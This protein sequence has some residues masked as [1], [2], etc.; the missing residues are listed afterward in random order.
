MFKKAA[1]NKSGT[2]LNRTGTLPTINIQSLRPHEQTDPYRLRE[3]IKQLVKDGYQKDPIIVEDKHMII[4]DGHHRFSALKTLGY[5]RILAY[6]VNYGDER[7]MLKTWYP[8]VTGSRKRLIEVLTPHIEPKTPDHYRDP[9]PTVIIGGREYSLRATRETIMNSLLWKFRIE[10]VSELEDAKALARKRE[11]A[12][13][14]IFGAISKKDVVE[15]ALSGNILPPKT[16]QH[17]IPE[18]PINWFAPL[19]MLR[20]GIQTEEAPSKRCT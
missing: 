14:I 4:L 16:T 8:V 9:Y 17:I 19:E 20:N 1:T 12:G 2:D 18:R 11:Y 7:I 10:Y 13:A 15:A 3:M 5:S 6:K